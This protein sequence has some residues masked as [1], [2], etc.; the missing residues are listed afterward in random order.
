MPDNFKSKKQEV[1][2]QELPYIDV[3]H[4]MECLVLRAMSE[5]TPLL[6]YFLRCVSLTPEIF[7]STYR[8]ELVCR[9]LAGRVNAIAE[10]YGKD[11]AI[12]E[13]SPT[14]IQVVQ[15]FDSLANQLNDALGHKTKGD[16]TF[17][18]LENSE[19]NAVFDTRR[20][21]MIVYHLVANAIQHGRTKNKN[22]QLRVMSSPERFELTV[23][24]YGGGIP[25]EI[26]PKIFTRF[27]EEFNLNR[28]RLGILPPVVK[29]LGLPLCRKLASDM[30]GELRF[31]N[32]RNGAQ[33]TVSIPQPV[34]GLYEPSDYKPDMTMLMQCIAPLLLEI[35][36]N[37]EL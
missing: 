21:S 6:Q 24:D 28:Q 32:Y 4:I 36:Q 35:S 15:F 20:M 33:F 7:D 23:R 16:I 5:V 13:I 25:P 2:E 31:R 9:G 18:L 37:P 34:T 14:S 27:K 3:A 19:E 11:D 1:S 8:A 26:Q 29:G 12:T 30:G 10:L 22:V 17:V